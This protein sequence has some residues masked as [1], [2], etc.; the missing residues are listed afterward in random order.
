L[1]TTLAARVAGLA[2]RLNRAQA[3]ESAFLSKP[4]GYGAQLTPIENALDSRNDL[5]A[6]EAMQRWETSLSR[7]F[8]RTL[9]ELRALQASRRSGGF[10]AP[11]ADIAL[12]PS[13][14]PIEAAQ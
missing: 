10:P 7:N 4:D 11:A 13:G 1:E 2:W 8:T 3:L 6:L 9:A 14:D 12:S 5:A